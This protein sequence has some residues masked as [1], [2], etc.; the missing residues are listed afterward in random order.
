M[1]HHAIT[2]GIIGLLVG[3]IVGPFLWS[4]F[5]RWFFGGM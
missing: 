1:P 5:R 3:L 2:Y 4:A